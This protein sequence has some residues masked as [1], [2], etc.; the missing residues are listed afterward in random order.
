MK[1][2]LRIVPPW[3][4]SKSLM[5]KAIPAILKKKKKKK[6][7][8]INY[9]WKL[10]LNCS[11]EEYVKVWDFHSEWLPYIKFIEIV[12]YFMYNRHWHSNQVQESV[13]FP[14]TKQIHVKLSWII[15]PKGYSTSALLILN[16]SFA[17]SWAVLCTAGCSA[18]TWIFTTR[19]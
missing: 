8:I 17:G 7:C 6:N 1:L 16:K 15:L 14:N 5:T 2:Y 4:N 19:T 11:S 13:S 9:I 3:N 12:R 18:T 10:G